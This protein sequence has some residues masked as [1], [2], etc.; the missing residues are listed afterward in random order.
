VLGLV[1]LLLA[2]PARDNLSNAIDGGA[3][4]TERGR[5]HAEQKLGQRTGARVRAGGRGRAAWLA[6]RGR[7][8]RDPVVH[9][10]RDEGVRF[11]VVRLLGRGR[12]GH[13]DGGVLRVGRRGEVGVVHQRDV[14]DVVGGGGEV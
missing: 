10:Q 1:P 4:P 5:V 14:R 13:Y 7:A 2:T 11:Q 12:G 3:D 8:V 9:E 6:E